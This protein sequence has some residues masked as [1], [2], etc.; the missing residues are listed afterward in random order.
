MNAKETFKD[1]KY[2]EGYYQV[3]DLG[4]VRSLKRTIIDKNGIRIRIK[5]KIL[6]LSIEARTG[7]LK[8]NLCKNGKTKT[9]YVHKLVAQAFHDHKPNGYRRII[10][11]KNAIKTDNRAINLQEI[12]QSENIKK[13]KAGYMESSDNCPF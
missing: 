9:R 10:D 12:S 8:V 5:K 3:S 13:S 2:Y 6:K 11:H 4:R 7:Y 1:I